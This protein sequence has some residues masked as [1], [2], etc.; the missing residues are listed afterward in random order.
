M[1]TIALPQFNIKNMIQDK[2]KGRDCHENLK[3]KFVFPFWVVELSKGRGVYLYV[4]HIN[5]AK[6]K[7][8]PTSAACFLLSC[9]YKNSELE[10]K[11]LTGANAKEGL[12]ADIVSSILGEYI[13][14]SVFVI[15]LLLGIRMYMLNNMCKFPRLSLRSSI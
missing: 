14:F 9:F 1:F 8:S 13:A 3:V 10:G 11:N 15:L 2:Y 7:N 4:D 12:N 6:S 5:T